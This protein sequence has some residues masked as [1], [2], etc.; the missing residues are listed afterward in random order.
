M[1]LGEIHIRD[2]SMPNIP[3]K[4]QMFQLVLFKTVAQPT[5]PAKEK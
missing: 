2:A 1:V 5:S 4:V 3:G